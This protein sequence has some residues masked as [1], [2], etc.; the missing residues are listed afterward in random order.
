MKKKRA[1]EE[2]EGR[3]KRNERVEDERRTEEE[4]A[5]EEEKLVDRKM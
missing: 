5:R 2:V 1:G 4:R 3:M